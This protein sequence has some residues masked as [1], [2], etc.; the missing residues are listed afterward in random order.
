MGKLVYHNNNQIIAETPVEKIGKYGNEIFEMI[1]RDFDQKPSLK[2]AITHIEKVS[3]KKRVLYVY[4]LDEV[5]AGLRRL[6]ANKSHFDS[7]FV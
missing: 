6:D 4:S 5:D 7:L 3:D 1:Q 2:N